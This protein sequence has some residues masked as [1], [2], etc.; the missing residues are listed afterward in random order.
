M[1][2]HFE[3]IYLPGRP[4]EVTNASCSATKARELLDYRESTTLEEGLET[5]INYIKNRGTLE[6][7]YSLPIEIRNDLTPK[8]WTQRLI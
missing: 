7:D 3:P 6:F 4:Q 5:I 8:S 2:T 1:D